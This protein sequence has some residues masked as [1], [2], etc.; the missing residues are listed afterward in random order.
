MGIF[1]GSEESGLYPYPNLHPF[2]MIGKYPCCAKTGCYQTGVGSNCRQP[3]DTLGTPPCYNDITPKQVASVIRSYNQSS[4]VVFQDF[5]VSTL[6][7]ILTVEGDP[8]SVFS[9]WLRS[10]LGTH[11]HRPWSFNY[12]FNTQEFIVHDSIGGY[13]DDGLSKSKSRHPFVLE[14]GARDASK[15]SGCSYSDKKRIIVCREF[16]NVVAV[17]HDSLKNRMTSYDTLMYNI[18]GFVNDWRSLTNRELNNGE[19]RISFEKFVMDSEYRKSIGDSLGLENITDKTLE[20]LDLD[21]T[22]HKWIYHDDYMIDIL[23]SAQ[24]SQ[25]VKVK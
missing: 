12:G 5:D 10:Q 7:E 22:A 3:L 25:L 1:G 21:E 8:C 17:A 20:G 18:Y 14:K 24:K 13:D 9:D 15:V 11:N 2:T 4:A 19:I 6:Y 16:E 23:E